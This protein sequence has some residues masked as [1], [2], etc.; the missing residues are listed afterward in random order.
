MYV[1]G[2]MVSNNYGVCL[3]SCF[4]LFFISLLLA[5]CVVMPPSQDSL[6]QASKIVL[7]GDCRVNLS[8]IQQENEDNVEFISG[9]SNVFEVVPVVNTYEVDIYQ[10]AVQDAIS[11]NRIIFGSVK[12]RKLNSSESLN[13]Q[14]LS[15]YPSLNVNEINIFIFK[16]NREL[17][18]VGK[19]NTAIW[20]FSLGL[21]PDYWRHQSSIIVSYKKTTQ[22]ELS[23]IQKDQVQRDVAWSPFLLSS[24]SVVVI[25]GFGKIIAD[26]NAQNLRSALSALKESGIKND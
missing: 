20:F 13:N 25:D 14:L 21:V 8:I 5:A 18:S 7:A 10:K 11:C 1:C 15:Y 9:K 12:Y 4:C 6:V 2:D 24:K 17:F 23:L 26:L 22:S 16:H 3:K 19:I